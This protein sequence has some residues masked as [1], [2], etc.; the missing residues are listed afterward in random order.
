MTALT[1]SWDVTHVVAAIDS[2]SA[3]QVVVQVAKT[4]ADVLGAPLTAVHVREPGDSSGDA[5]WAD[6]VPVQL[7]DCDPIEALVATFADPEV[8]GVI[9]ARDQRDDMRPAG[10]VAAKVIARV[11]NPIVV[12]GPTTRP[13]RHGRLARVLLPLDGTAGAAAAAEPVAARLGR[14]GLDVVV[15][16]VFDRKTVPP[17][18]DQGQHETESWT[19]EFRAR[20]CGEPVTSV[21]WSGG[22]AADEI[23]ASGAAEDVDLIALSWAQNAS[24]GHAAIVKSVLAHAQVP[25]LLVTEPDQAGVQD[26][27]VVTKDRRATAGR[28][29]S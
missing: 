21:T 18:W 9:G 2:S 16:H 19:Q 24:P 14:A 13:P 29:Q 26:G 22:V 5:T 28:P 10:G 15:Q 25:V 4:M 17:F 12:V 6:G 8:I 7:V 3:A 1:G 20:W 11:T 23:V 27:D